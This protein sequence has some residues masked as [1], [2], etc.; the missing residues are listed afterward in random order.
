MHFMPLLFVVV[1]ALMVA[2]AVSETPDCITTEFPS[3]ETT[4]YLRAEHAS[5]P[6]PT[7]LISWPTPNEIV[8]QR[9]GGLT[10]VGL[11][12]HGQPTCFGSKVVV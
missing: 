11:Q 4:V 6:I 9:A 5:E 7:A 12:W 8:Q 2:P 1:F 3:G 10:V